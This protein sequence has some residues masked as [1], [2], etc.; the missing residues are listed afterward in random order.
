[1]SEWGTRIELVYRAFA[2]QARAVEDQFEEIQK[3]IGNVAV[4]CVA[5]DPDRT[6]QVSE[7]ETR[8][9]ALGES[10]IESAKAEG[11]LLLEGEGYR[12][13]VREW[14][15]IV[16]MEDGD[17][18]EEWVEAIVEKCGAVFTNVRIVKELFTDVGPQ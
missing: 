6:V 7:V 5:I 18:P 11:L 4:G 17:I 8:Y 12:L 14:T 16:Q 3:W 1:M 2:R 9:M 13:V 10:A 15:V